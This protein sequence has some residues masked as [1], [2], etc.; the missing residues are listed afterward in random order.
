[1]EQLFASG[2]KTSQITQL[3]RT[4]IEEEE[5]MLEDS[6]FAS[7]PS[8]RSKKPATL[9]LSAIVHGTLAGALIVIPLFQNQVLPQIPLFEP[10]HPP[11]ARGV[12][13][14]PVPRA[15][16]GSSSATPSPQ[17]AAALTTPPAIPPTIRYVVDE[18]ASG[19]VGYLPGRGGGGA[20]GPGGLFGDPFGTDF[21]TDSPLPPLRAP[22][23][24]PP[25]PPPPRPEPAPDGPI[26]RGGDVVQSNLI[27][28]VQP[29]Y[30]RLAVVTRTQGKV[31]LE[32]VITREGTIDSSRLRVLHADSPLLTPGAVD[33]V[34]QWR[35]RPTLLNGQPVEVLTTIT[36]T[37]TLNSR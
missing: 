10:L 7:R 11:V 37:F 31:I 4:A 34:K 8:A 20:G 28:T 35:Y 14:V 3:R 15:R 22:V 23:A 19:P 36:I 16:A 13:L 33:A 30:P 26:R 17:P 21:G 5:F 18:P 24:T 2:V 25:P 6:L 1:V 12:E 9:V 29:V 32:A 27:H